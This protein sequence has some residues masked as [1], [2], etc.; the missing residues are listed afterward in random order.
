MAEGCLE[1]DECPTDVGYMVQR[2]SGVQLSLKM[3][4]T[5]GGQVE[6]R[7]GSD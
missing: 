7:W 4:E 1:V 6:A 2:E 5:E 3:S